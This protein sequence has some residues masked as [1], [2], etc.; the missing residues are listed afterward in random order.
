MLRPESGRNLGSVR[1]KRSARCWF[2]NDRF[3]PIADIAGNATIR[4]M[5]NGN[6]YPTIERVMLS[7]GSRAV[8]YDMPVSGAH[9]VNNLACETADGATRWTASPG[10][11][12]PDT[13]VAV[14]L[15]GDELVAN[16]WSGYALW[17]DPTSGK[18]VRRVF[19]K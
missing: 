11:F 8:L 7:D 2:P 12:G 4:F 9:V 16:T 14:R 10:E 19:A 5:S 17:L 1:A 15:D 6:S 13:F 18:E 3:P